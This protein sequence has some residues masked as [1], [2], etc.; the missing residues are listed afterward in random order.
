[1]EQGLSP[2]LAALLA[3]ITAGVFLQVV[4]RYAFS[5][6]FLWAEE[7]SLFAFIWC[8]YLGAAIGVWR[9]NHFAFDFLGERLT[10]GQPAYSGSSSTSPC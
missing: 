9:R 4:L 3:F 6:S 8:I 1:M 2:V 5:T 7:L 10:D